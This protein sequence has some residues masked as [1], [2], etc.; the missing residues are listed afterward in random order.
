MEIGLV[1]LAVPRAELRARTM[2]L[3]R[4]LMQVSP[5]VLRAA[6]QA[7]HVLPNLSYDDAWAYLAAKNASLRTLDPEGSRD[8]GLRQF[9]D[10]K[11]FRPGLGAQPRPDQ[12]P[13]PA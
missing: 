1:N 12:G 2:E 7:L 11:V 5:A 8:R 4:K 10:D 3:A 9:I 13:P 6:K